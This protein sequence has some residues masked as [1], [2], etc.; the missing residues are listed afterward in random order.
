MHGVRP[1]DLQHCIEDLRAQDA[2]TVIEGCMD[3][4]LLVQEEHT[5]VPLFDTTK[6]RKRQ[7]VIEALH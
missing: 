2:E 5:D 6:I 4:G 7:A 3:I 1:Q